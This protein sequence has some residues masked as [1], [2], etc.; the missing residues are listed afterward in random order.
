MP[1]VDES[2]STAYY[3]YKME[4][5]GLYIAPSCPPALMQHSRDRFGENYLGC[6]H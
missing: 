4:G 6:I 3:R 1:I 5:F 2:D